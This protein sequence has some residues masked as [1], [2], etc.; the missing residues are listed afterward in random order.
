MSPVEI[1]GF[2]FEEKEETKKSK[3]NFQNY[4]IKNI[5]K[6]MYIKSQ[7]PD[8]KGTISITLN[9][10]FISLPESKIHKGNKIAASAF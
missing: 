7:T 1:K 3:N 5:M 6:K 4:K 8:L 10:F 9:L 2:L